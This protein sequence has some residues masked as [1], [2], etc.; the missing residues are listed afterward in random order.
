MK[1]T[2]GTNDTKDTKDTKG[3]KDTKDTRNIGRLVSINISPG[4]V[5]KTSVFEA[6]ISEQGVDGD[7]QRHL[8]VHGGPDRAVS[9]YSIDVIRALQ[10]EGHPMGPGTAGEN[11]TL[12]GIDWKMVTPGSELHVGPVRL[13]VTGYAAPCDQIR[14]SFADGDSTR[15]SQKRHPGWSRVYTRVASAGI[16]QPGDAVILAPASST[17]ERYR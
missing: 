12:S 6:F 14:P 3:T 11:L 13:V 8:R 4:G 7:R 16:V 15:I 5:P 1:D 9:V 10:A 17:A 2:Q